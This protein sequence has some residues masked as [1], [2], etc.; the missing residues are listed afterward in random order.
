MG[1]T[2]LVSAFHVWCVMGVLS[3]VFALASWVGLGSVHK[4]MGWVGL[5]EEKMDP[6]GVANS[7]IEDG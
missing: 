1:S 7:R 5:G 4:L 6:C 3:W 2:V